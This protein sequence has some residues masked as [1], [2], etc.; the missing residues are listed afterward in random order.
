M[1]AKKLGLVA[2]TQVQKNFM[3]EYMIDGQTE[4]HPRRLDAVNALACAG[5]P[6]RLSAVMQCAISA[7]PLRAR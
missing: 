2:L 1:L 5:H 3:D 6:R 4:S 7:H